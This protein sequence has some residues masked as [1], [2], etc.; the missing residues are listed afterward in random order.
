VKNLLRKIRA[1]KIAFRR[2]SYYAFPGS[3]AVYMSLNE[4]KIAAPNWNSRK[5]LPNHRRTIMRT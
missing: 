1:R 4:V 5:Q 2:R 3:G